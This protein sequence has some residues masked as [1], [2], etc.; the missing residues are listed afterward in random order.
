MICMLL[1]LVLLAT[2]LPVLA[3][4]P[5]R[6]YVEA[7]EPEILREFVDLLAIPNVA[8]DRNNI[9]RNAA[10]VQKMMGL[11]GIPTRLLETPGAPPVVFGEIETPG[12]TRTL[13]FYAHYDG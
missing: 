1:F 13:I 9:R 12:A 8:S 4:P 7:H 11:R 3:Q 6:V 10:L 2:F 5:V